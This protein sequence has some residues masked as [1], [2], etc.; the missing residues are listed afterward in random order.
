MMQN[1]SG[2]NPVNTRSLRTMMQN[3]SGC[4]QVN[5][6]RNTDIKE[7]KN[8]DA[9]LV[10]VQPSEYDHQKYHFFEVG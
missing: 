7:F 1:W 2:C 6:S 9:K 8:N 4:N 10:R 5:T 3:W